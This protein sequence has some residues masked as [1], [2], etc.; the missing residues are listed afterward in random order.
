MPYI[1]FSDKISNIICK[2]NCDCLDKNYNIFQ[3]KIIVWLKR[4]V[5]FIQTIL[6]FVLLRKIMIAKVVRY[7]AKL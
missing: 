4:V 3:K 2:I 6:S 1:E 5:I 7:L